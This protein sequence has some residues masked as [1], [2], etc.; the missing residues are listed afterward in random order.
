MTTS[1]K[2]AKPADATKDATEDAAEAVRAAVD[3]LQSLGLSAM[4]WMGTEWM[5]KMGDLSAEV[6]QFLAERVK[7]DV[8]FQHRLLHCA[9]MK[10]VHEIQAEFVQTAIDNYTE[11]TGKLVEMTTKAW[12][13]AET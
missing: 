12:A 5:E 3:Q 1:T 10:E 4:P 7:R 6:L 8:E 2:T 11:E 9:D 13:P